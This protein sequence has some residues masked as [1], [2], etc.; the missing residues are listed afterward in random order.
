MDKSVLFDKQEFNFKNHVFHTKSLNDILSAKITC[1]LHLRTTQVQLDIDFVGVEIDSS[2]KIKTVYFNIYEEISIFGEIRSV[3]V[4]EANTIELEH[5]EEVIGNS[6]K[7]QFLLSSNIPVG[8]VR[9]VKITYVQDTEDFLTH[10]NYELGVNWLR[11]IGN[12]NVIII[13]DKGISLL[14]CLPSPHSIST[15]GN[16]LVLSWLEV[17]RPSFY[18]DMNYTSLIVIDDLRISPP[19][20]D[21][22]RIRKDSEPLE[23]TFAITNF[24]NQKLDGTIIKPDWVTTN[25]TNWELNIGETMYLK[26]TIDRSITRDF[27][28][29][30][31]L[32]CSLASFPV[33]I[34]IS[35]KIAVLSTGSIASIIL[36]AMIIGI[37]SVIGIVF[38]FKKKYVKSDKLIDVDLISEE[39]IIDKIDLNKWKELL[40]EREFAIFQIIIDK[41]KLT[42]AELVRQTALSKSTVSRAV[43]RLI[44]K[45]LVIKEKY[46][47]SN[48]VSL[49]TEFFKNNFYV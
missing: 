27:D 2:L 15:I 21:V 10:Y 1:Y 25:F 16:K 48:F 5:Y 13:C 36:A 42:Q 18:A 30:I 28:C 31:S 14:N 3:Q 37:S 32:Q 26:I 46:G 4:V 47:I 8:F 41:S 7:I 43:G 29:N 33:D 38:Y 17:N 20:W 23:K 39:D 6:T 19:E 44:A 45:G 12:Q 9:N 35:G 49:N 34:Q 11:Q 22:G 24:E 40:T